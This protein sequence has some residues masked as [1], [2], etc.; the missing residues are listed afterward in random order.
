[1]NIKKSTMKKIKRVMKDIASGITSLE[2]MVIF[3]IG[4]PLY[5]I[6]LGIIMIGIVLNNSPLVKWV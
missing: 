2:L 1:M 6:G 4:V 5:L 3:W